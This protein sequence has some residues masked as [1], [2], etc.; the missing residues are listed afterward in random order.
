MSLRGL[1]FLD[2]YQDPIPEKGDSWGDE[3]LV[4]KTY[5]FVVVH[6]DQNNPSKQQMV[7]IYL[8]TPGK[9]GQPN[10]RN[11]VL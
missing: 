11:L 5:H 9:T 4:E 10:I 6:P 8:N 1:V 7:W 3:L 2:I